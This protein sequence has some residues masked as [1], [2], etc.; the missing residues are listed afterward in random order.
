MTFKEPNRTAPR[1]AKLSYSPLNIE[2]F[3]DI[4]KAYPKFQKYSNQQ[5]GNIIKESNELLWNKVIED[6]NGIELESMLGYIFMGS[7]FEA[8]DNVDFHASAEHGIK[9]FHRNL[10][11]DG[12]LNKIF[13]TNLPV[14]YKF[15]FQNLWKFEPCRNFTNMSSKEYRK[16]WRQ[17]IVIPKKFKVHN[18]FN[19]SSKKSKA[20]LENTVDMYGFK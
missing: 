17:Y 9:I 12:Y 4:K 8:K 20:V 11:T 16:R 18:L 10:D 14:K 3:K 2:F 6:R 1:F 19:H 5:I 15:K 7:C 13:Y